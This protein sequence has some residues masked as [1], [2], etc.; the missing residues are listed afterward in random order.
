M[1]GWKRKFSH[2]ARKKRTI[3]IAMSTSSIFYMSIDVNWYQSSGRILVASQ[4]QSLPCP[5]QHYIFQWLGWR[6][7]MCPIIPFMFNSFR[8]PYIKAA[9][10]ECPVKES[11]MA[12][13]HTD[14]I[15]AEM[16]ESNT[17]VGVYHME[18][19]PSHKQQ[20][21]T[22]LHLI[23]C[24]LCDSAALPGSLRSMS[25]YFLSFNQAMN[26]LACYSMVVP[27]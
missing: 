24:L 6:L 2:V 14:W 27:K 5:K 16:E 26:S 22:D 18:H 1:M 8:Q 17:S 19:H 9:Y 15:S 3:W 13:S 23:H 21:L 4:T 25:F 7:R 20:E 12:R 10:W 11:Q